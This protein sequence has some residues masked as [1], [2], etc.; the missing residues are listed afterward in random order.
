MPF[1]F[2]YGSLMWDPSFPYRQRE[3]AVLPRYHR[4][5]VMAFR[6]VW[7]SPEAP[8]AVLGLE[9][10]GA[11][12]GV[13]YEI[14]AERETA[15]LEGLAAFEGAAFELRRLPIRLA[16][17]EVEATVAV[18]RRDTEDYIGGLSPE[19]RARMVVAA[20]GPSASCR[21]YVR[22]TSQALEALGIDDPG[23]RGFLAL[24]EAATR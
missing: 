7:G 11:C 13:A 1:V 2:G 15:I 5:F 3:R 4:A 24:V 10:G 6:R 12:E 21:D 17:G 22:R 23:V 18:N 16:S 19:A 20:A 8:C 9:P 14:E